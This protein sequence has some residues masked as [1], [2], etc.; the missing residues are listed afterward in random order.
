MKTFITTLLFLGILNQISIA[1]E[2]K[3][4]SLLE[5][6]SNTSVKLSQLQMEY[7][8][9]KNTEYKKQIKN[10]IALINITS[11][12]KEIK[13]LCD[14]IDKVSIHFMDEVSL[15]LPHYNKILSSNVVFVSPLN[16]NQ[17]GAINYNPLFK[18]QGNSPITLGIP[19][20]NTS[21]MKK[22]YHPSYYVA[23]RISEDSWYIKVLPTKKKSKRF[24][25][26]INKKLS[27]L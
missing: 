2:Q 25:N 16:S 13:M 17:N 20:N 8:T 11:S 21:S 23:L 5:A 27:E 12:K 3:T 24:C 10:I 1:R 15:N 9:T 7:I 26:L 4:D 22:V 14:S 18:T 19:L 6:I